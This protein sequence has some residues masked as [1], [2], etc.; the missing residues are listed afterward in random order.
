MPKFSIKR[1]KI[2]DIPDAYV[3]DPSVII[4]L[5]VVVDKIG[6]PQ[7]VH[8]Q[9]KNVDFTK[10]EISLIDDSN[11]STVMVLWEEQTE[12][13]P[14]EE[15]MAIALKDMVIREFNGG[16]TVA[17][18]QG[19]K[20]VV[21]PELSE[22]ISLYSWYE[23]RNPFDITPISSSGLGMANVGEYLFNLTSLKISHE[24]LGSN[25]L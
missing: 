9:K 4:D 2:A 3:K 25:L 5:L 19:Y 10:R 11:A 18:G 20:M 21:N 12:N 16:F 8:S 13:L 1:T 22:T 24:S 14:F 17:R 6:E 23:S 7:V 15:G